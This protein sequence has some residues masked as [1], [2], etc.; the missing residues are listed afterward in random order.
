LG[1][2]G[3]VVVVVV[4]VVDKEKYCTGKNIKVMNS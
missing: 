2:K 4:V 3:F 1:Q